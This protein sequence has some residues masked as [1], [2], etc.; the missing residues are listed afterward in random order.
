MSDLQL[1]RK[2]NEGLRQRILE[3]EQQQQSHPTIPLGPS[4]PVSAPLP[5]V[6]LAAA[7]SNRTNGHL[8]GGAAE[9]VQA[10]DAAAAAQPWSPLGWS[11]APHGLTHDQISR[12][13]RQL[14]LPSFGFR[15]AQ[16]AAFKR[17]R[18]SSSL[19]GL[20][21]AAVRGISVPGMHPGM[22][23]THTGSRTTDGTRA[24]A[25]PR[26]TGATSSCAA[27]ARLCAS[28]VLVVGAGGLGAPVALYLAAAGVGRLGILDRDA[29]ELSNL[30]RQV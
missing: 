13:S 19:L 5:A 7:A 15:G 9:P 23:L 30:H 26:P 4:P 14:L 21:L 1:L 16:R 6:A 24:L 8:E 25:A 10:H 27:Q 3:I 22:V 2:E 29:V 20:S 12:Y 11:S 17:K 18:L 28:S